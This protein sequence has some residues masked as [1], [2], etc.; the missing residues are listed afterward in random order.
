M[1]EDFYFLVFKK[2][3]NYDILVIVERI[4]YEIYLSEM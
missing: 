2:F 1:K 3:T 4:K